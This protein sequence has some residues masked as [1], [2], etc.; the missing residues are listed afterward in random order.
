M[1]RMKSWRTHPA[2][3]G[4]PAPAEKPAAPAAQTRH[5]SPYAKPKPGHVSR[6]ACMCCGR[7]FASTGNHNRLCDTCRRVGHQPAAW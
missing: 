6:R 3:A 2:A 7:R 4:A 1:R 5:E